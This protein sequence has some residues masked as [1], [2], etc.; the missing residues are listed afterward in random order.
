MLNTV[1]PFKIS[2]INQ[3]DWNIYV[4]LEGPL[5]LPHDDSYPPAHDHQAPSPLPNDNAGMGENLDGEVYG[6]TKL[7]RSRQIADGIE[8]I[9][10]QR[11]GSNASVHFVNDREESNEE[12]EDIEDDEPNGDYGVASD[13]DLERS[14]DDDDELLAGPGQEGI[15]LWDSLGEGFLIEASQLGIYH[16]GIIILN[17]NPC[18]RGKASR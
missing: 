15:S 7:H 2:V 9:G 8:K 1:S 17:S 6:L 10:Q 11:W 16:S 12:E 14:E 18:S 13:E 3:V 5:G 4:D